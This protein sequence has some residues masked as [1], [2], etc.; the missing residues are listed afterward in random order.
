MR[1]DPRFMAQLWADE[2]KRVEEDK[3]KIPAQIDKLEAANKTD[4]VL[5]LRAKLRSLENIV[6]RETAPTRTT[7]SPGC[8]SMARG[9]CSTQR[10]AIAKR[11][12][13]IRAFWRC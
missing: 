2:K 4:E 11:C 1:L 8:A 3:V 12:G 9:E 10:W 13:A 5:K 7:P 6:L